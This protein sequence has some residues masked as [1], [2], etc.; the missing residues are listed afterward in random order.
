MDCAARQQARLYG[1]VWTLVHTSRVVRVRLVWT[2][3][4]TTPCHSMV[5]GNAK[6]NVAKAINF[7]A[8]L[9]SG[10]ISGLTV[11]VLANSSGTPTKA[12]GTITMS[13][14]S[15]ASTSRCISD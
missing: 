10:A 11:D 5:T 4:H 12:S 9:N 2:K 3:V 8:A 1:V 13:G 6:T 15:P 14:P 7:L